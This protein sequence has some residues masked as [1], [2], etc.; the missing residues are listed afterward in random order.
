MTHFG[1]FWMIVSFVVI[2]ML[3]MTG[4]LASLC[5]VNVSGVIFLGVPRAS[6]SYHPI[7]KAMTLPVIWLLMLCLVIG[8]DPNWLLSPLFAVLPEESTLPILSLFPSSLIVMSIVL[9]LLLIFFFLLSRFWTMQKAPDWQCGRE[10]HENRQMTFTA[11]TK[12]VRT[13]LA[14]IYRPH[15]QL[16]RIGAQAM[17]FPDQLIYRGGVR[18]VWERYL[19]RPTYRLIWRLSGLTST[20]QAGSIQLYLIY[21]LGTIALFLLLVH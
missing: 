5:F 6:R 2:L 8:I 14:M 11:F 15:R 16:E 17:Y 20:L 3:A 9:M 19:Y 13:T 21:M 10:A 12:S 7:G 18:S 4:A 1:A